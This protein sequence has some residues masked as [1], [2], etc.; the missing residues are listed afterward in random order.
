VVRL[1]PVRLLRAA[2]RRALLPR[3]RSDRVGARGLRHVRGRV[4]DAAGGRA[5]FG[6]IG[7]KY[8]RKQALIGSVMAMAF[9]SFLVALL[10]DA[11]R[12]GVLAP[13]LL[14]MPRLIQ[15]IAVGGE[16]MASAVFLVE[17][18]EPGWRGW[19]GSWGPFGASAG[20]LL[21]SAAGALVNLALPPEAV[22]AWGW[23]IPF[24]VGVLV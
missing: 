9:P 4:R 7:D 17:G 10:P 22:L 15:G 6:W 14:V 8:G 11:A 1:R 24:A 12:I 18:A 3:E 21:G 2:D 16:Y 13:V 5:L 20:T 19:M 23:R